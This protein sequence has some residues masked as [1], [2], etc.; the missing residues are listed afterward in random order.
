MGAILTQF[1]Q[2]FATIFTHYN[3]NL[4]TRKTRKKFYS[5]T[6]HSYVLWRKVEE[7]LSDCVVEIFLED[8]SCPN[9]AVVEC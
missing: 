6:N 7:E 4:D 1:L 3:S 5:R 2:K 8:F 9:D